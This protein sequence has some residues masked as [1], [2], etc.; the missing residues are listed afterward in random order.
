M[1][2]DEPGPAPGARPAADSEQV[3]HEVAPRSEVAHSDVAEVA[4][5]MTAAADAAELTVTETTATESTVAEV[6]QPQPQYPQ[7]HPQPQYPQP[8]SAQQPQ[9]PQ[10]PYAQP[11][12]AP[13][14]YPQPP[15][16]LGPYA[17]Q[18]I[19]QPP[20]GQ[21][22]APQPAYAQP[23]VP[24]TPHAQPPYAP[25]VPQ[26]PYAQPP[27]GQ[28]PAPQPPYY[29]GWGAPPPPPPPRPRIPRRTLIAALAIILV[30]G[31]AIAGGVELAK[32][33]SGATAQPTTGD[34]AHDAAAR[35][36]WRTTPINQL[37]PATITREGTESY[38]RLGINPD[39]SCA[40]LPSAVTAALAPTKC[41][42]LLSA[43][44]VDRTQTVTATVGI[45]VISGTIT[46]R[47]RLFQ[48]WNAD[49]N[50]SNGSMMPH[51]YPVPGT[52]AS[53]FNDKQRVAWQSQLSVDGTYL[54][55][56][57][58]GFADG[59]NGPGTSAIKAGSGSALSSSSPAVQVAGDLPAAI[60]DLLTPKLQAAQQ[61]QGGAS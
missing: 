48:A 26:P 54:A 12:N 46:D 1:A 8:L 61:D 18:P 2:T 41:A 4:E 27:Y 40:A 15:Y 49:T 9:Y 28:Q 34:A 32:S 43:T 56:A 45:V 47:L 58:V 20:Y 50:A 33:S 37:L 10:P 52:V 7:P 38:I 5:T 6:A 60:Q 55:Y 19:P 31:G 23:P 35:A 16:G 53:G 30:A 25:P 13:L 24:Q 3:T 57:V 14:P 42:H 36:V 39:Y 21:S 51:V 59:R 44:Y 22:P 11:P 17:Q 29:Y